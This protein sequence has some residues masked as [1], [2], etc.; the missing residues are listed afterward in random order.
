MTHSAQGRS[1][2]PPDGYPGYAAGVK[3]DP[4]WLAK[5]ERRAN[6]PLSERYA[7]QTRNAAV[8]IAVI[9]C[10]YVLAG[11]IVCIALLV[12]QNACHSAGIC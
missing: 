2:P 5:Q 11:F 8:I 9:M 6:E 1:V 3:R 4:Q 12:H 7:R 10:V